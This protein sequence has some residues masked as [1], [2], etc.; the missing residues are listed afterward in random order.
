MTDIEVTSNAQN[1]RL[2]L[3]KS[4]KLRH[5][6]LVQDLF[7]K[8]K[9]VY[10]GPL[11]VTFHT[12]SNEELE[13]SFRV[14]I[15]DLMGPVQMMITVPKKKRR[16]AVDRVLMRRRI[17]E[18]FRLQWHHLKKRVQED[19]TIRTLSLAIVYMDTE[20]AEMDSIMIAMDSVLHKVIKKLFPQPKEDEIC[21]K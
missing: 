15:P 9:S 2:T 7:Q 8:G 10:S 21:L 4:A 19:P 5:R 11:R 3:R 18:A 17:R 1:E 14:R 13:H 12:L 20:N 6:T 16:H